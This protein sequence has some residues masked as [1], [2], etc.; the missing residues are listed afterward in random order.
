MH[1]PGRRSTGQSEGIQASCIAG[2]TTGGRARPHPCRGIDHT[3][4]YIE[5]SSRSLAAELRARSNSAAQ[6]GLEDRDKSD[7]IASSIRR[8]VAISPPVSAS[9]RK[10][11]GVK[12][13]RWLN[14]TA[15]HGTVLVSSNPPHRPVTRHRPVPPTQPLT[16]TG[17]ISNTPG[18]CGKREPSNHR[19]P[20]FREIGSGPHSRHDQ[21]QLTH[22]LTLC[23]GHQKKH[24]RWHPKG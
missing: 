5:R 13:A 10:I 18:P 15:P 19:A 3:H 21:Q 14:A 9:W 7:P 2:Q 16:E 24:A 4:S 1:L 11:C 20:T 17:Q 6:L 23:R 12:I 8:L 22:A